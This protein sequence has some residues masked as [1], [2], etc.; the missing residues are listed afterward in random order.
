M[1]VSDVSADVLTAFVQ[2]LVSLAQS[3]SQR[4]LAGLDPA[5]RAKQTT[6]LLT[7]TENRLTNAVDSPD[8]H[9]TPVPCEALTFELTG[10]PATMIGGDFIAPNQ[11]GKKSRAGRAGMTPTSY[12][13][14]DL[15][16]S[17]L[18]IAVKPS[19][20]ALGDST[21]IPERE[22]VLIASAGED[23]ATLNES[24]LNSRAPGVPGG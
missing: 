14:D 5:D 13:I 3:R 17:S 2:R 24:I 12:Y 7:Y 1:A 23:S 20:V 22:P 4:A 18:G 15:Y 9:R 10:Y 8:A 6:T 16:D 19:P 21:A 11:P